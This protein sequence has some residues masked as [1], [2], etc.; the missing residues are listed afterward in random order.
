M[1]GKAHRPVLQIPFSQLEITLEVIA[2]VCLIGMWGVV[3]LSWPELPDTIPVHFNAAGEPDGWGSKITLF[4]LPAIGTFL[5]AVLTVLSRFPHVYNYP[6]SITPENARTQYSL[7]RTMIVGLKAELVGLFLYLEWTIVNSGIGNGEGPGLWFLPV[8]LLVL[9]G[10]I[11]Y[12][13]V[14]ALKA[15]S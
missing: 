10:T 12:Y 6:C 1:F 9:F 15:R 13:L 14:K 2:A 4:F 5:F 8:F 3:L 7:A 11:S